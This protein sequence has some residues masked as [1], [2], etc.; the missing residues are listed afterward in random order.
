[1]VKIFGPDF[2][3]K[4]AEDIIKWVTIFGESKDILESKIR[5]SY[6]NMVDDKQLKMIKA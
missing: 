6:G 5:E 1:M 3:H 2:G 4:M